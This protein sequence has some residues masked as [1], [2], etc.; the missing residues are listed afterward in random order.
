[1][2]F[3]GLL[4]KYETLTNIICSCIKLIL[5]KAQMIIYML[6]KREKKWSIFIYF[7]PIKECV[8]PPGQYGCD[9]K[10]ISVSVIPSAL[11]CHKYDQIF[12]LFLS[13]RWF[14]YEYYE[15]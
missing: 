3:K 6:E 13:L 11:T 1:M 10:L 12:S 4:G 9:F 14:T 7:V 15:L 5:G 8:L 2:T